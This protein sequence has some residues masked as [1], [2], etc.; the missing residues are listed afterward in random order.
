MRLSRATSGTAPDS[1]C[2]GTV[3]LEGSWLNTLS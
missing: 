3:E 2:N 1:G